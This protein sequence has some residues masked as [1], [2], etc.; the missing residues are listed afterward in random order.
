MSCYDYCNIIFIGLNRGD[1][2]SIIS[3]LLNIIRLKMSACDSTAFKRCNMVCVNG[4][5]V[6]YVFKIF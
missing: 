6:A 1:S 3:A 2:K 4:F 5:L